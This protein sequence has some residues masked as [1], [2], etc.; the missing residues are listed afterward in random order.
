MFPNVPV[1][2]FQVHGLTVHF[3]SGSEQPETSRRR[4]IKEI[5][6]GLRSGWLKGRIQNEYRLADVAAAHEEV[7][8][9]GLTGKVTLRIR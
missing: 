6:G 5:T 8:R 9:G 3:I 2:S 7:E 1:L 4:A